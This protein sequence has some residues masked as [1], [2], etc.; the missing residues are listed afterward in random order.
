[1]VAGE[2]PGMLI[3]KAAGVGRNEV[4]V[5]TEKEQAAEVSEPS[6]SHFRTNSVIDLPIA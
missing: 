2:E 1:M 5:D 6:P 3:D 4:I